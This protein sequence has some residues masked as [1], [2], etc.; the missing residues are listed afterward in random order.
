MFNII[1]FVPIHHTGV[2]ASV[3][4]DGGAGRAGTA[5]LLLVVATFTCA[6]LMSSAARLLGQLV[7]LLKD[8]LRMVLLALV[9]ALVVLAVA[10]MAIN[11]LLTS[12]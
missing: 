9:A 2:L 3:A 6:A 4:A 1:P 8:L 12:R 7:G 10:A 5:G 11:D